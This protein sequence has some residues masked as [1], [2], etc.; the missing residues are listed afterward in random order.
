MKRLY[1]ILL[2]ALALFLIP[3]CGKTSEPAAEPAS[4]IIS[5]TINIPYGEMGEPDDLLVKELIELV[6]ER[7]GGRIQGVQLENGSLGNEPD[8]TEMIQMGTLDCA[9][10]SDVGID[11]VIGKLGWAWLPFMITDYEQADAFYHQ[12]WIYDGL[13]E[14]MAEAG[15]VRIASTEV[16]LKVLANNKRSIGASDDIK[17]LRVRVAEVPNLMRFYELLGALPVAL[18]HSA[19]PQAF[20]NDEIDGLNTT[21]FHLKV[22][23]VLGDVRYIY[24]VHQQYDGGSIICSQSFWDSLSPQDQDLFAQCAR[25]AGEHHRQNKR[26]AERELEDW[27]RQSGQYVITEPDRH[28]LNRFKE[29]ARTIWK[30]Y[31]TVYDPKMMEKAI[32]TFGYPSPDEEF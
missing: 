32:R 4:G 28:S 29:I 30:E 19:T 13:T 1:L 24:K 26:A 6:N 3:G 15:I 18:P 5:F 16:G 9:V 12:G 25:I 11:S 8:L 14:K 7:S 22:Q 27:C 23:G 2:T 31:E 17:G 10:V 21:F 20:A